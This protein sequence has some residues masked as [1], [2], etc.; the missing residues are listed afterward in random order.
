MDQWLDDRGLKTF[1]EDPC[2]EPDPFHDAISVRKL[3]A[4]A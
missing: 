3:E 1:R 2:L 4:C